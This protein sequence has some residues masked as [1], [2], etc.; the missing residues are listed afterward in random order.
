ME[1]HSRLRQVIRHQKLFPVW[2]GRY[3]AGLIAVTV[4]V[5]VNGAAGQVPARRPLLQVIAVT[6]SVGGVEKRLWLRLTADGIA[7]WEERV[8]GKPN[9]LRSKQLDHERF[10]QF[11]KLLASTDWSKIHGAM[12]AYYT[13]KDSGFEYRGFAFMTGRENR[14]SIGNVWPPGIREKPVPNEVKTF[15]CAIEDLR[16]QVAGGAV[17]KGCREDR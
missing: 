3:N 17:P 2:P 9:E 12:G 15:V 1:M 8:E 4:A 5:F 11:E 16:A 7:E 13:Y 10:G 6:Y 14:F